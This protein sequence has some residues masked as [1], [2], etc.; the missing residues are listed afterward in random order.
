M[1]VLAY[2]GAFVL[3]MTLM[4]D[5]DVGPLFAASHLEL[6]S[7]SVF[8]YV[9][10]DERLAPIQLAGCALVVAGVIML[11]LSEHRASKAAEE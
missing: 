9:W 3:Y 2:C 4:K 8:A 10:L 5:V 11:G 1:I 6:V 7:V